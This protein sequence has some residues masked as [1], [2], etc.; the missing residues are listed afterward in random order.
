MGPNQT[1]KL[2]LSKETISKMK[3]QPIK[4]EKIFVNNT[5]QGLNFQNIQTAHKTQ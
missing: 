1:C 2:L 4:W 3:R 5:K